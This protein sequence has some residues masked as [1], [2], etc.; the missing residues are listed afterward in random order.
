MIYR[1]YSRKI[2]N[3][4]GGSYQSA[5][6]KANRDGFYTEWYEDRIRYA[7]NFGNGTMSDFRNYMEAN[8]LFSVYREVRKWFLQACQ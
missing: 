8:I 4:Y 1:E 3:C 2:L 6:M 7:F 5:I